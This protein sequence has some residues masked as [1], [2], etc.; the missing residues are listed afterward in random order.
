MVSPIT[1]LLTHHVEGVVILLHVHPPVPGPGR[2]LL[3]VLPPPPFGLPRPGLGALLVA[4]LLL[5]RL[6]LALADHLL[7]VE[8]A[9]NLPNINVGLVSKGG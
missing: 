7:A 3:L 8:L 2:G 4:P 1:K 6:A 9:L 5:Q